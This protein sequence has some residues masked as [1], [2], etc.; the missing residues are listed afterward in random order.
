MRILI[1]DDFQPNIELV[2]DA[3]ESYGDIVAVNDGFQAITEFQSALKNGEPFDL[4]CLDIEMPYLDG[5]STLFSIRDIEKQENA[6]Q[7]VVF[8]I[9]GSKDITKILDS[10]EGKANAFIVKDSNILNRIEEELKKNK[11]I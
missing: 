11:L 1:A 8:M 5:I 2:S 6:K 4:I 3:L 10:F 9:T 7:S